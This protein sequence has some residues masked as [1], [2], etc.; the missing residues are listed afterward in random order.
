M[1]HFCTFFGS[2]VLLA[3]IKN[4]H[5]QTKPPAAGPKT[6]TYIEAMSVFPGLAPGDSARSDN[7]RVVK[8]INDG[9]RFPPEALR[10][11]VQGRVSFSFTVNAQGRT[12][13][14]KLVQGI[15]A[16][17][18]AEVLRNA[19]RLDRIQWRP[20]T[21]NG[22]PV[23]VVFTVPIS[24]NVFT[25]VSMGDSL[26]WGPY[27]RLV[28]PLPGWSGK[29]PHLPA[30][31]G[32]VYGSCLQRL[33]GSNTLGQGQYV[34][35]VNLTTRKSFRL[36]VKPILNTVRENAFCYAL[37]T[38]RYALSVY[39]FPEPE[40]S[41]LRIHL[42]SIRKAR[43]NTTAGGI[44]TT[45]ST[46]SLWRPT[47]FTTWAPGTWPTKTSHSSSTRNLSSTAACNP[48]TSF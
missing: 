16:D 5:G 14:I 47:E 30:G 43:R 38:G 42:E 4:A 23:S 37:P 28:L 25:N 8:F 13:D 40:W 39:K 15:R 45:R 26:D 6:Y 2:F 12:T 36:N 9:I 10:D 20:G 22:R 32:L 18:D 29:R 21:Q 46:S 35:L 1:R 19:H 17:V 7:Q 34:R 48:A 44:G 27:H 11:G 3:L 41:G 31:K 24:F 33:G